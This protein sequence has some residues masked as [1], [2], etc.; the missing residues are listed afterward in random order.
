LQARK[1]VALVTTL[2]E[3]HT[4]QRGPGS[5]SRT[6]WLLILGLV[7]AVIVGIVLVVM[8]TGGGSG[9]GGGY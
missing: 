1:E 2:H 6:R 4:E 3:R 7:A 8:L 9:G 5:H